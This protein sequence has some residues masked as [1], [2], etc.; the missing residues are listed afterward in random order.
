MIVGLN[1]H[2]PFGPRGSTASACAV[3][4]SAMLGSLSLANLPMHITTQLDL[5]MIVG[6]TGRGTP[7]IGGSGNC[8]T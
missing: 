1:S 5:L 6:V 2:F 7:G 8:L 4:S 3:R